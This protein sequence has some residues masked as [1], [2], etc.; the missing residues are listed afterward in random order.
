MSGVPLAEILKGRSWS[1][2]LPNK[3]FIK[4][5]LLIKVK[6]FQETIAM[7]RLRGFSI[8]SGRFCEIKFS[9]YIW[10]QGVP[11]VHPILWIKST[12][13]LIPLSQSQSHHFLIAIFP[14]GTYYMKIEIGWYTFLK[15]YTYF[16]FYI[17][18]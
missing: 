7:L 1:I 11:Y 17:L 18:M 4:R 3:D 9:N 12:Y 2:Y 15:S 10:V 14:S 16:L 8:I 6:Y 5:I 13:E